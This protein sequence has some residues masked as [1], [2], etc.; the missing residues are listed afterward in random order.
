MGFDARSGFDIYNELSGNE[1]KK[2]QGLIQGVDLKLT[3][4]QKK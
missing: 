3:K 1:A 2:S 4:K